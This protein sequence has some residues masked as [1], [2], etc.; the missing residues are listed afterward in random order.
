[1]KNIKKQLD[2][3]LKEYIIKEPV[4]LSDR[5][6]G[7]INELIGKYKIEVSTEK[8]FILRLIKEGQYKVVDVEEP[9]LDNGLGGF[10]S[11]L[12]QRGNDKPILSFSI[13]N[14]NGWH[15]YIQINMYKEDWRDFTLSRIGI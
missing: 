14:E 5:F 15:G 12:N 10:M 4:S 7:E 9:E 8:F 1:M 6:A 11:K 3:L 2:I 13:K